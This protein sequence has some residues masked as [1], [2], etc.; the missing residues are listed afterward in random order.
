MKREIFGNRFGVLMAMA[1]SAVGLGN[2]WRFPYMAGSCGGAAFI[3]VYVVFVFLLCLPI[4]CAETIIGRRS[5]ANAFRAFDRLAPGSRWKWVGALMVFTPMI[6][7]SYYSVIGGWSVEYLLKALSFGFTTGTVSHESAGNIFGDY[8]SSAWKPVVH[9]TVFLAATASVVACGVKN[10]IEKFGKIMMPL[11]F[12]MVI[13]IAVRSV[14]LP[15]ASEGLSYLFRPD[16]SKIDASVCISALGQAFFSL[17][18][19]AGPML[20]YASYINK[21]EN[22]AVSSS[23]T[24]IADLCFAIIA[25]VAIMPAVFSFGI[26]PQAGPGLVFETLPFIFSQMPLGG[27]I[28]ILFFVALF[29]AALTSSI[30]LFEVGVAWLV[31]ERH[32]KRTSASAVVFALTWLLGAVCSLSFGP[33]DG[34]KVFGN[35]IFNFLDKLSADVLMTLG[36]FLMVIFVGWKLRRSEIEDEFTNGGTVPA[37]KKIFPVLY[38]L[39][40]YVAPVAIAI[41]FVSGIFS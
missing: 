34:I 30:S 9:H 15:G 38:F 24:A 40:K 13:A 26:S 35:T 3:F 12:L 19:G 41:I 25:G 16:F 2:L 7:V 27:F 6:V 39:I 36:A 8:I 17:S 23:Y 33:L 20:A 18:V 29:V 31:E 37:N 5:Q 11:L 10:G 32:M 14:T 21:S 28:A 1:G 4:L 22:I